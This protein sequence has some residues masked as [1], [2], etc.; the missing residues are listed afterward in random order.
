[1]G[2]KVGG[3]VLASTA[4][5][6]G[7]RVTLHT[8]QGIQMRE[9]QGGMGF[10]S[11]SEYA[12]HFGVPNPAAVES[13]SVQWPSSRRQEILGDKARA[14]I[15]HHVRL[16]EGGEAEVVDPVARRANL[17]GNNLSVSSGGL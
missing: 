6:V 9:V 16:V 7:A 4:N 15:N 10:A 8:R 14:L 11:Q 13:I 2:V 3:R 17:A 1:M 12:V 5:A